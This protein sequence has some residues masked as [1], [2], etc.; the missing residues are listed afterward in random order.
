ML[1]WNCEEGR[2]GLEKTAVVPTVTTS[3]GNGIFFPPAPH[4][5]GANILVSQTCSITFIGGATGLNNLIPVLLSHECVTA[6]LL[7]NELLSNARGGVGGGGG[8]TEGGEA[9]RG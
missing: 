2:K 7:Q 5:T 6:R 8:A 4:A 9:G 3:E 1:L